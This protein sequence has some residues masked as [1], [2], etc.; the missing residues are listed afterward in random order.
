MKLE[1]IHDAIFLIIRLV[2]EYFPFREKNK[3]TNTTK[4]P[5]SFNEC[6]LQSLFS[7]F[8]EIISGFGEMAS[9]PTVALESEGILDNSDTASPDDIF[10]P[11]M[12]CCTK[13]PDAPT[14][15]LNACF[16]ELT[17]LTCECSVVSEIVTDM[18]AEMAVGPF[19]QGGMTS[20]PGVSVESSMGGNVDNVDIGTRR[21]LAVA[22]CCKEGMAIDEFQICMGDIFPGSGGPDQGFGGDPEQGFGP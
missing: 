6:I 10:D 21:E 1:F 20:D 9:D 7:G 12:E 3:A 18:A 14:C 16:G 22:D 8:G 4:E 17:G 13:F 15:A 19:M 2:L 11:T 5:E